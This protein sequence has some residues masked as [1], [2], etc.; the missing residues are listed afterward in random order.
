MND[1]TILFWYAYIP[2]TA[3]PTARR[4]T[5]ASGRAWIFLK[6]GRTM[7][8][9]NNPISA[10]NIHR[11]IRG[12]NFRATNTGIRKRTGRRMQRTPTNRRISVGPSLFATKYSD[13]RDKRSNNG[14]ANESEQN[15]ATCAAIRRASRGKNDR[16]VSDDSAVVTNGRLKRSKRI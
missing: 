7:S 15:D 16:E 5:T 10:V 11:E 2:D 14:C 4:T 9:M 1:C 3:A 13:R 8:R 6:I 12:W